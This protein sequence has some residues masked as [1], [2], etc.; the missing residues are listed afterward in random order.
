MKPVIIIAIAVVLVSVSVTSIF[1]QSQS[2]IPSWVKGVANFWVEGNINDDEFGESLSF[3]IEQGIIKVDMSEIDDSE[4][5]NKIKQLESE[6]SKL[7]SEIIN[8][9]NQKAN[10]EKQLKTS[11]QTNLDV[12][13]SKNTSAMSEYCSAL[14]EWNVQYKGVNWLTAETTNEYNKLCVTKSSTSASSTSKIVNDDKTLGPE[15]DSG[16][17]NFLPIPEDLTG[18]WR[19]GSKNSYIED[20]EKG[21]GLIP[22]KDKL[23]SFSKVSYKYYAPK[24]NIQVVIQDFE[25]ISISPNEV[26]EDKKDWNVKYAG[27]RLISSEELNGTC[28]AFHRETGL[29]NYVDIYCSKNNLGIVVDGFGPKFDSTKKYAFSIANIILNKI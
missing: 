13:V 2:E 4:L 7:R 6:N 8:L 29:G 15:W 26:L 25:S 3:L 28:F 19:L 9:K 18:T 17:A 23:E 12:I 27:G 5:Q 20:P 1:A 21:E 24:H 22:V 11:S 16:L 14:K 10:L